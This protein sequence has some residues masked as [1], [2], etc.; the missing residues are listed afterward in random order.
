MSNY[1]RGI[2]AKQSMLRQD[3][4]AVERLMETITRHETGEDSRN[5]M[6]LFLQMKTALLDM[7]LCA[8]QL[9]NTTSEAIKTNQRTAKRLRD[10]D[11]A[12]GTLDVTGAGESLSTREQKKIKDAAADSKNVSSEQKNLLRVEGRHDRSI[13][14]QNSC[15]NKAQVNSN[16]QENNVQG[17]KQSEQ[18][19]AD[20][21]NLI[22]WLAHEAQSLN[23][24][25]K[26]T[27]FRRGDVCSKPASCLNF[28]LT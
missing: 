11:V 15:C 16:D 26:D 13:E 19:E 18:D 6:K 7:D 3:V 24:Q 5:L 4:A 27:H 17:A 20:T 22:D 10:F 23:E 1:L 14:T 2:T 21:E 12:D 25:R 28:T 9:R 8:N